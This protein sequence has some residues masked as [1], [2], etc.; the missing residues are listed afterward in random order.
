MG[1]PIYSYQ[2]V[3]STTSKL[4]QIVMLY[5][6][7]IKF[8]LLSVDDI[9]RKDMVAKAEHIDRSLAIMDYL[10]SILDMTEGGE[11]ARHLD[12]LYD[13]LT[14]QII[15]ANATLDAGLLETSVS[16][17]REIRSAWQQIA[18]APTPAFA[19]EM[20]GKAGL[21]QTESRSVR[22]TG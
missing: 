20:P 15:L 7:A 12:R 17:L 18:V 10:R 2:Q 11:V 4:E 6:G 8:L 13:I 21:F 3:A 5:D 16:S 1:S 14:H 19:G 22:M 9:K